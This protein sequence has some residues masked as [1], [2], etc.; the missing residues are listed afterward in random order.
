LRLREGK[1]GGELE[2]R[3]GRKGT[4]EL[5]WFDESLATMF[6]CARMFDLGIKTGLNHLSLEPEFFCDSFI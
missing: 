6:L 4:L 5:D 1:R 2:Q 3:V